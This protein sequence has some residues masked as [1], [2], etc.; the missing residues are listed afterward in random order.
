M[1]QPIVVDTSVVAALLFNE[2]AASDVANR[3]L[4]TTMYAPILIR[5]ELANVAVIKARKYSDSS[6]EIIAGFE[7]LPQ[8]GIKYLDVE[9]REV[10]QLAKEASLTA[11]DASFMWLARNLDCALYSFDAKLNRIFMENSC[12]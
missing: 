10:V 6:T 7:L 4:D 8:L 5:Y 3:L 9:D 11:Y 12:E 1:P 2:P